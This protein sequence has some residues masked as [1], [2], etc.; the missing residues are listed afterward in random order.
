MKKNIVQDVVFPK[1]S[2]KEVT[3]PSR[4]TQR[5]SP[6]YE[7][8]TPPPQMTERLERPAERPER[9]TPTEEPVRPRQNPRAY[10][11]EYD[12]DRPHKESRWGLWTALVVFVLATLFGVFT[13]FSKATI[14]VVPHSQ[15]VPVT[16]T[17]KAPKDPADGVFGYQVVSISLTEEETVPATKEEQVDT[18]ASG[19]ITVY[20]NTATPQKLIA[21]T[22]FQTADGLVYRIADPIT[23][24]ARKT[25]A[26]KTVPGSIDAVVTADKT[27]SSYN[28][29]PSD[30]TLP[31]LA[32]DPRFKDIYA[33]SKGSISGG[34]SGMMKKIDPA[35][36]KDTE[37]TLESRLTARLKESI[38]TQIPTN[39]VLYDNAL[40]T[41]F[42]PS[43]Q[44]QSDTKDSAVLTKTG[45]LYAFIFDASLLSKQIISQAN[46]QLD[47]QGPVEISNIKDLQVTFDDG[48][49]AKNP[50]ENLSVGVKGDAKITWIIDDMIL[51][52]DLAGVKKKDIDAIMQAKYPYIDTIKVSSYPVWDMAIPKD[53]SKIIINK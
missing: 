48:I 30:F 52:N 29:G 6:E 53:I 8:P 33:K 47:V 7:R 46:T 41:S 22:R 14:S 12:I 23:V 2:I 31:G 32:N 38:K 17:L 44:K 34:A 25:D 5:V 9:P 40:Y 42:T 11:Y 20:N 27:G 1:R 13:F 50:P 3:L 39:F 36:V 21:T 16:L 19:T 26:G 10:T 4:R 15:T 35:V 51:K 43:S 28:I 45:T 18:K 37:K 24:P 49:N